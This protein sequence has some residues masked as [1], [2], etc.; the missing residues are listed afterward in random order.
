MRRASVAHEVF[1]VHLEESNRLFR[2]DDFVKM[3]RLKAYAGARRKIRFNRHAFVRTLSER[4]R[5]RER[6]FAGQDFSGS[7]E[8]VPLG[9]WIVAQV[10][11]GTY[12]QALLW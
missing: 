10:P 3:H 9:V 11:F 6:L 4:A 12:F 5:R 1:R 2:G 7:S 8:P